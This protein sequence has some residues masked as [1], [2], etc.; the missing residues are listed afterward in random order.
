MEDQSSED[1]NGPYAANRV[2]SSSTCEGRLTL[3]FRIVRRLSTLTLLGA[4]GLWAAAQPHRNVLVLVSDEPNVP[5]VATSIEA[6]RTEFD[7]NDPA[8]ISLFIEYLDLNRFERPD[9]QAE[10]LPREKEKYRDVPLDLILCV[11]LPA[12]RLASAQRDRLWPGIPLSFMAIDSEDL[13]GINLPVDVRGQ[14]MHYDFEGTARLALKLLPHTKH[15]AVVAGSAQRDELAH[16]QMMSIVRRLDPSI[17]LIDEGGLS[18]DDLGRR[19]SALPNETIVLWTEIT[20]D[21]DGRTFVPRDAV[22]ALVPRTNAPVFAAFGTYM[23]TGIVGGDLTDYRVVGHDAAVFSD[24]ILYKGVRASTPPVESSG[25]QVKLD[26]RQVRR[27]NISES[28]LPPGTIMLYRQPTVWERYQKYIMAGVVVIVLQAVLITALLSQ[29]ARGRSATTAL[30]KLGGLL[31]HSQEEE[32]ASIARELHDDFSQRLAVQC[33]ELEQLGKDLPPSEVEG[34][35]RALR[36]LKGTQEM[37]ADMRSLSHQLHSSRLELVGLVPA[38]NGLCQ[39]TTYKYGITVHFTEPKIIPDLAKDMGLCLF[40][41]AQEALAN[42][43]KHSHSSSADVTLD[44]NVN[45]VS[46]RISDAGEGFDT[47][48]NRDGIGLLS[49]RERLKLLGGRLSVRSELMRGTEVFAE[50]PLSSSAN[51]SR[52][53][54]AGGMES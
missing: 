17:D 46:L 9:F 35:N 30:K 52:R 26:W 42:V 51:R 54:A 11:S 21:R 15:V 36:M 23:G 29:R 37:S 31:I 20:Q 1:R 49:M 34:R 41:V 13:K 24:Q 2:A 10:V 28:A 44:V 18:Y 19:L 43:I 48:L 53:H 25:N 8:A 7:R 45:D 22:A 39:E 50:I 38:L 6:L 12:L 32:R 27:W 4:A 3:D 16:R 14:V 5:A 40:R 33:M 47:D